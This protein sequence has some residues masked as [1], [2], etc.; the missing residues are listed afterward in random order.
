MLTPISDFLRQS[1]PHQAIL[2]D[3]LLDSNGF[4]LITGATETGKSYLMLQLACNLAS[5]TRFLDTFVVERPVRVGLIQAEIGLGRFQQRCRKIKQAFGDLPHLY[6]GTH[7]NLKLNTQKG[8]DALLK[9][10]RAHP[11]DVLLLDP[12]RPFHT[13]SEND[14]ADMERLLTNFRKIQDVNQSALVVAQHHR[15]PDQFKEASLW[16]IRGSTVIT[17]RPDTILRLLTNDDEDVTL[18]FDKVRNA[19][20]HP[21]EIPLT[22]R[23]NGLFHPSGNLVDIMDMV[24]LVSTLQS[25]IINQMVNELT[26]KRRTVERRVKQL[27]ETGKI[28]RVKRGG[29]FFIERQDG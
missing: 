20:R 18:I 23:P 10:V 5:G 22:I 8:M 28:I 12:M 11:I 14:D 16:D 25:T 13:G 7:Y 4:M 15:K 3:G 19:D 29:K 9:W 21:V 6:V 26:V 24:P 27:V 17:D 2:S 1:I